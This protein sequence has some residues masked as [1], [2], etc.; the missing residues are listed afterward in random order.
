[1]LSANPI[2]RNHF[3]G[4]KTLDTR[5]RICGVLSVPSGISRCLPDYRRAAPATPILQM[6][7]CVMG[8]AV[9]KQHLTVLIGAGHV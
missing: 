2:D 6:E 4:Q 8:D 7:D 9:T 3:Y 1:M 5:A